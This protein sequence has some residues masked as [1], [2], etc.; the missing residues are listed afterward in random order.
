MKKENKLCKKLLLHKIISIS[1]KGE[2]THLSNLKGISAYYNQKWM[3]LQYKFAVYEMHVINI[4]NVI[5][6]AHFR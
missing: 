5:F 6:S 1:K 2:V 4:L 3:C